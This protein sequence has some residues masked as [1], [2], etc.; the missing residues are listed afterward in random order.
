MAAAALPTMEPKLVAE[1]VIRNADI[2]QKILDEAG[3]DNAKRG[4]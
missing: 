1:M 2:V 3:D 4:H